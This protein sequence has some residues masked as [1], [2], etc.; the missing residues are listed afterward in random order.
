[1][2]D[3][4]GIPEDYLSAPPDFLN[5][6]MLEAIRADLRRTCRRLNAWLTPM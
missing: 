4:L 1:M 6:Q 5:P 3:V 2:K